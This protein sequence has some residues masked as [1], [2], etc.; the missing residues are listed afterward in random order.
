MIDKAFY[1]LGGISF[2]LVC[3]LTYLGM[4]SIPIYIFHLVIWTFNGYQM[5]KIYRRQQENDKLVKDIEELIKDI[6]DEISRGKK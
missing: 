3:A 2:G 5:G 4:I 6:D 1:I